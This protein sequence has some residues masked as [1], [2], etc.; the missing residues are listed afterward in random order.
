M[1]DW[2]SPPSETYTTYAG[3][4]GYTVTPSATAHQLGSWSNVGYIAAPVQGFWFQSGDWTLN[5]T[6]PR[7]AMFDIGIG[8]PGNE[9]V[10]VS[11]VVACASTST[12]ANRAHQQQYYFPLNL[13]AGQ[14]NVRARSSYASTGGIRVGFTLTTTTS[15]LPGGALVDTYGA[16]TASTTGTQVTAGSGAA[17]GSWTTIATSTNRI[18]S[19]LISVSNGNAAYSGTS[20]NTALDIGIG[21]NSGDVTPIIRTSQIA[22]QAT[23]GIPSPSVLGPYCVDLPSGSNLYARIAK[24]AA[25]SG[26]NSNVY[27]V[28]YGVR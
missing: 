16:V 13:P 11:N 12:T 23:T 21:P 18:R 2:G 7:T 3:Y 9:K 8:D 14:V 15:G 22:T 26:A 27:L 20:M 1:A 17:F 10:I 28:M 24:D 25:H 4:G 6:T 5:N 19:L